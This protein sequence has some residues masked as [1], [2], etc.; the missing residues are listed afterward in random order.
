M[1]LLPII[2]ISSSA[3]SGGRSIADLVANELD[4]TVIDGSTLAQ[5]GPPGSTPLPSSLSDLLAT[6]NAEQGWDDTVVQAA[7]GEIEFWDLL[8][9]NEADLS[10]SADPLSSALLD[11]LQMIRGL[12]QA[13]LHAANAQP[14]LILLNTGGSGVFSRLDGQI[15]IAIDA[16]RSVRSQRFGLTSTAPGAGIERLQRSDDARFWFQEWFVET[17]GPADGRP[18]LA[19]DTTRLSLTAAAAAITAAVSVCSSMSDTGV[20]GALCL[21]AADANSLLDRTFPEVPVVVLPT[22]TGITMVDLGATPQELARCRSAL[23]LD[24]A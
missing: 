19:L 20:N 5:L 16:A 12:I 11:Q 9:G 17:I 23:E 1:T 15:G 3:G 18:D 4:L 7:V 2:T 14:G 10:S 22:D 13:N 24:S 8:A 6:V 21:Q